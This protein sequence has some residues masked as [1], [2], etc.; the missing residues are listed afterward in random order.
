MID[1]PGIVRFSNIPEQVQN[2]FGIFN[3]SRRSILYLIQFFREP[4]HIIDLR[5]VSSGSD[6]GA[7]C[8]PVGR[9]GND[10]RRPFEFFAE[11]SP[12]GSCPAVLFNCVH[13]GSMSCEQDRH[14]FCI[15]RLIPPDADSL[16]QVISDVNHAVFLYIVRKRKEASE[17]EALEGKR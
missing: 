7:S 16:P 3:R 12:S 9:Y 1:A 6:Q 8:G 2:F 5:I 14:E 4:V 13:R 17:S 10:D 15:H 11:C